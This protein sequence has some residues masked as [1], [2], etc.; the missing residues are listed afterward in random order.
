MLGRD[1]RVFE[2]QV[3]AV[4]AEPTETE[5]AQA[6]PAS[7]KS[8]QADKRNSNRNSDNNSANKKNANTQIRINVLK[9]LTLTTPEGKKT[10][11]ADML[12]IASGF[13]GAQTYV[14][15]SADESVSNLFTAGDANIG[16]SLV[17]RAM[18]NAREV[19]RA[20]DTHLMG[21]TSIS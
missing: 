10:I 9:Q 11:D 7:K 19:A 18:A 17:V 8:A 14:R 13:K 20:V 4:H 12:I 1:I 15:A 6:E 3:A 16:S 21:Y 2:T 5:P